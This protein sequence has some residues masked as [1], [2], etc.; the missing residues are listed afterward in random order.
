MLCPVAGGRGRDTGAGAGAGRGRK[1]CAGEG[2][3]AAKLF[4]GEENQDGEKE[5]IG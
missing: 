4:Y 2:A 3:G 5:I 1:D